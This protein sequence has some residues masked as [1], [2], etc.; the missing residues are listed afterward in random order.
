MFVIEGK[1]WCFEDNIDTDII[2]P[3]PYLTTSDPLELSKYCMAGV[4][5]K[6]SS[7]VSKGDIIVAGRN[8]GCGSSREHAPLAIKGLGISCVIASSFARIFFRN[9]INIGL[10]VVVLPDAPSVINQGDI[11]EVDFK[12]GQVFNKTT[13]ES[14]RFVPYSDFVWNLINSGGLILYVKAKL[15]E[16]R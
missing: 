10:P 8:F 6:F 4:D 7:K 15:K 9:A 3:A 13:A 12:Q 5:K 14:F 11:I 1:A 2:I 16:S